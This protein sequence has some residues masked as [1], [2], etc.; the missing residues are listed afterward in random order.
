[1]TNQPQ[2]SAAADDA[3]RVAG[4]Y[5][6]GLWH[7]DDLGTREVWLARAPESVLDQLHAMHPGVYLIDNDAPRSR[8]QIEE[9]IETIDAPALQES[10]ISIHQ[11]GPTHDGYVRVAVVSDAPGAQAKL[12]Q[13]FGSGVIRVTEQPRAQALPYRGA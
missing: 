6:T 1:V 10:G 2:L 4:E 13:M 5:Y 8:R 3:K 7:R 12:D 11:I 9:V